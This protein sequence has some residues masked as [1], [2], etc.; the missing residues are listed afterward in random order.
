MTKIAPPT[1]S[2]FSHPGC[3]PACT[4]SLYSCGCQLCW[5]PKQ[6]IKKKNSATPVKMPSFVCDVCQETLKKAK[7]DGHKLRCRQASFSCID[8]YKSFKGDEYKG[9]TSCITEVQKYHG[10]AGNKK[11]STN[12]QTPEGKDATGSIEVGKDKKNLASA[13]PTV[14]DPLVSELNSVLNTP[15]TLKELKSKLDKKGLKKHFEKR[16]LFSLDNG[17]LVVSIKSH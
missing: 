17:K 3:S 12:S 14:D 16:I 9:H 2:Q 5:D 6:K 10:S 7:L 4:V 15:L 1:S 13:N 11:L 8:C